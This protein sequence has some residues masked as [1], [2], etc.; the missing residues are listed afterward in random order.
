MKKGVHR[1]AASALTITDYRIPDCYIF[2]LQRAA[3]TPR[4]PSL[5]KI[6]HRREFSGLVFCP[7]ALYFAFSIPPSTDQ[8][9]SLLSAALI[10]LKRISDQGFLYKL[11]VLFPLSAIYCSAKLYATRHSPISFINPF[12]TTHNGCLSE[13]GF[14]SC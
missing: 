2:N 11:F 6:I 14:Q 4:S 13:S 5:R 10:V 9:R 1:H 7:T 8:P 3:L 12:A